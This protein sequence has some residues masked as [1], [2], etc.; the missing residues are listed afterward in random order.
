MSQKYTMKVVMIG[1]GNVATVLGGKVVAA[2]HDMLQ[3]VGRRREPAALLAGELGCT[4]TTQWEEIDPAADI[5]I[6]AISDRD[7]ERLGDVLSLPGRLV[8]HTAGA[9][10]VSALLTV[11]AKSG[12]LY[13]L[14]S[15]KAVVRPFPEIP[16]LVDAHRPEDLPVIEAFAAT[17]SRQVQ[18]AGDSA[19]LKMHLGAVLVNN[20][21]N[22][23]FTL[24]DDFCGK[25][26]LDFALLQ[27]IILETAERVSRFAPRDMQT[28][29]AVRGDKT[30]YE[31]HLKLLSNYKDIKELYDIFKIKIEEYYRVKEIPAS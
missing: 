5:Y 1:S 18:R 27:P 9:V 10:S 31:R 11:S 17:L 12:V 7:L 14:Q 22:F 8:L 4:Y 24:A 30:T 23:L 19:R 21:T 3:V 13:P 15:L 26:G 28:G 25:E 16:L 6:V 2:G 29:P 20:F